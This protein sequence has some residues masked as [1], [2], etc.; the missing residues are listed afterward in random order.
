MRPE[1]C[2]WW[3]VGVGRKEKVQSRVARTD[4]KWG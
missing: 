3:W 4:Q 1:M 2:Q